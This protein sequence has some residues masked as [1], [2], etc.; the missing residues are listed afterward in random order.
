[1]RAA[2]EAA[3][4][5]LPGD[6]AGATVAWKGAVMTEAGARSIDIGAEVP[7]R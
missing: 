5:T 1:M 6:W 7:A 3:V 4:D 2:R